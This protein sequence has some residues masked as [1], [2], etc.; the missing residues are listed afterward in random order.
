MGNNHYSLETRENNRLTMTFQVVFGLLCIAVAIYWLVHNIRSPESDS[1]L[2][3]TVAF[4][5]CFGGYLVLAGLGYAYRY[6]EFTAEQISL[7]KYA[8]LPKTEINASDVVKIE[9]YP[10]KVLIVMKSG[11]NILIRFGVT[12]VERIESIKDEFS[13]FAS[14]NNIN[15]ELKNE[16]LL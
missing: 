4:L 8:V 7:K 3:I 1:T 9:V 12:E 11:R 6:I 15:L 13:R 5:T 14:V 10:L 16:I 2:W